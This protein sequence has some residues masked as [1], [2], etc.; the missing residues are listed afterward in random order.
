MLQEAWVIETGEAFLV[1][2]GEAEKVA[3][4]GAEAERVSVVAGSAV[5]G[6]VKPF[7]Q[8]LLSDY[9]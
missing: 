8:G 2:K 5:A 3:S 4:A 9:G 1:E 6:L 7:G